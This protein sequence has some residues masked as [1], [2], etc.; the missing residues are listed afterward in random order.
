MARSKYTRYLNTSE[1]FEYVDDDEQTVVVTKKLIRRRL[2]KLQQ[3]VYK[4]DGT[5]ISF[6]IILSIIFIFAGILLI[7]FSSSAIYSKELEVRRLQKDLKLLQESNA[8][9][10]AQI[11]SSYD[12]STISKIA[13]TKLGMVKPKPYQIIRIQVPKQSYVILETPRK[14]EKLSVIEY[15]K[16]FFINSL[17]KKDEG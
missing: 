3:F 12:L 8:F 11:S 4:D 7:A 6:S 10:N 9:L 14:E 1:A 15:I 16:Q 17:F 2:R 5:G 13:T